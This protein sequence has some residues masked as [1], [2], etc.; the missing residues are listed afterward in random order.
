MNKT[1]S[2][3]SA[4]IALSA[5]TAT[6]EIRAAP[7]S[8]IGMDVTNY[9]SAV[10]DMDGDSNGDFYVNSPGSLVGISGEVVVDDLVSFETKRFA[11]GAA[12]G[13]SETT[14]YSSRWTNWIG[15]GRSYAGVKL[16]GEGTTN[17]GWIEFYLP[18]SSTGVIVRG[19]WETIEGKSIRA[20]DRPGSSLITDYDGDGRSDLCVYDAARAQWYIKS[21]AGPVLAWGMPWGYSAV[22]PVG[23][24]YSGDGTAD[25][26]VYD[27]ATGGWFI[28][29]LAGK[30]RA[31][32]WRWGYPGAVPVTGD[33]D[34]DGICDPA[35][36]DAQSGRWYIR[37]LAGVTLSMGTSWGYA[38]A[39]AVPGDYDGD[40]RAD[41]AVYD[42]QKGQW[43]IRTLAGV[44]LAWGTPW[45]YSEAA[46]VPGDYDGDGLSDLAVYDEARGL[47]Y[48]RRL[49]G[50]ILAW[51]G[52]WGYQG[53]V[54]VPGDYD[55]D[56]LFDVGIYSISDLNPLR[57]GPVG[58]WFIRRVT[59]PI[60]QWANPWGGPGL[61]PVSAE[62]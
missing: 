60:L 16:V 35:V 44:T 21:S 29:S 36:Y 6:A 51:A 11:W 4:L 3:V 32:D 5:A 10:L 31:W 39:V 34:N 54:A 8:N 27:E 12:I 24:D 7:F 53:A 1:I 46:P 19:A 14:D 17:W 47:W 30:V 57:Y 26:A 22:Q 20:G 43:Y 9:F 23:G 42:R 62:P 18:D 55:G 41:L 59:G 61:L 2:S 48:V 40:G 45:G 58:D 50:T 49:D 56:G 37:T 13:S 28:R 38:G 52:K 25:P 33:Y 15:T